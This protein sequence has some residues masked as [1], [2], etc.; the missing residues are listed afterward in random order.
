[1]T[2]AAPSVRVVGYVSCWPELSRPN[3]YHHC[4][5]HFCMSRLLSCASLGNRPH[6][7]LACTGTLESRLQRRAAPVRRKA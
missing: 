6:S 5:R 3:N 1:M 2:A 7:P 4:H